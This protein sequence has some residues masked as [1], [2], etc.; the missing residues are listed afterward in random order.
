MRQDPSGS[1]SMRSNLLPDSNDTPARLLI[2][3]SLYKKSKDWQRKKMKTKNFKK[4]LQVQIFKFQL[5]QKGKE[6]NR[7][8]NKNS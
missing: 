2:C 1:L 3:S 5:G 4:N 7:S 6:K 8:V